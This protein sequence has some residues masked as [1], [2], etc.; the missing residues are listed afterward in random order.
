MWFKIWVTKWINNMNTYVTFFYILKV[1][2]IHNEQKGG[3]LRCFDKELSL[4]GLLVL[5]WLQEDRLISWEDSASPCPSTFSFLTVWTHSS[6]HCTWSGSHFLHTKN[7]E[8]VL[9][10]APGYWPSPSNN[11]S[12]PF[13]LS[14]CWLLTNSVSLLAHA[15]HATREQSLKHRRQGK[16]N[17][18]NLRSQGLNVLFISSLV[19]EGYP[20][21]FYLAIPLTRDLLFKLGRSSKAGRPPAPSI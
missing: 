16:H 19:L 9:D 18:S 2:Y 6:F 15:L 10:L 1:L 5:F 13:H 17:S 8:R 20:S 7:S 21:G 14:L 12:A 3:K 4:V 11:S